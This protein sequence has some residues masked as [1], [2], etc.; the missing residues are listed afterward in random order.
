MQSGDLSSG[1]GSPSRKEKVLGRW[2]YSPKGWEVRGPRCRYPVRME[3]AMAGPSVPGAELAGRQP[4]MGSCSEDPRL[5]WATWLVRCSSLLLGVCSIVA[6]SSGAHSSGVKDSG[7]HVFLN[8]TQGGCAL[9]H[10]TREA[11]AELREISWGYGPESDYTVIL[12]V[13]P[14]ADSPTWVS[15][16]DKYEQRVHVPNMTSLR[17]D[18]LTR[19][20]SGQY[21]ARVSFTGGKE[22]N[23]HFH[24][25]V[26]APVPLPQIRVTSSSITPGWCNVTLECTAR[27]AME[28]LKVAWE[29]KGLPEELEQ[30]GTPGPAPNPWALDLSL[31]LSQPNTRLTCVLSNS[32]DK[33]TATTDLGAICVPAGSRVGASPGLLAHLLRAVIAVLFFLGAG[34]CLWKTRDRKQKMEPGRGNIPEE[35]RGGVAMALG[36]IA[37]GEGGGFHGP[38]SSPTL[39]VTGGAGLPEE[40][41]DHNGGI[42]CAELSHWE[43]RGQSQEMDSFGPGPH[44]K[45]QDE[46]SDPGDIPSDPQ[47]AEGLREPSTESTSFRVGQEKWPTPGLRTACGGVCSIVANSSG[48]HSSGVKDSGA[49]VFLNRTQGGCALFHATR[50]AGAELKEISW[51]FGPESDY[52]VILTVRP[53]ADSPTWVSLQDKYEQSVHVPSMTSLRIDNLTRE[54]SGQYRARVSFTGGKEFILNFHL[55]VCAPVPLPQIRVTSSS[56]TPGWCTVTVECTALGVLEDLKVAWETKGL[57]EELEQR[58]TPGPARNSW[59]LDLSLP[60]SQPNTR[61]TCVLSNSDDKKTA[62]TDLGAI[63]VPGAGSPEEHRDEDGGIYFAALSPQVPHEGRDQ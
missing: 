57:P 54:D 1:Q 11:G 10:A 39:C 49:H 18:N 44:Q 9:F 33:K 15:L 12:T 29:T 41:R 17:I 24:L 2:C 52:T 35:G 50:E 63:C 61:L 13:R 56:I 40:H 22:F 14:G 19:E 37:V 48:A 20:D 5:C 42:H 51:A 4:A 46:S 58:G 62:T 3:E 16:Q 55:T 7:A 25:T 59:T 38:D 21:R 32:D 45:G 36:F 34:L 23:L 31:P 47:L 27:G 8:R 6:N 43:S 26:C 53:G 60:L 28:D 30:R